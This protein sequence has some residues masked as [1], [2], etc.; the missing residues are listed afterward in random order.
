[1]SSINTNATVTLTVNGKQAQDMLDNLTKKSKDLEHAIENAAKAGNKVELKRLQKELKQTNRQIAQIESATAGVEKVLKNL[2]KATPKELNKTLATLKK[3]LNGIERGTE[4]WH[5]QAEAIKRVKAELAKVN[6]E[7]T[8]GEGFWDRFNRK[9]NDWQTTLMGMIAAATGIIMAGRSAVKAYADIDAEMANVRKFTGMAKEQVEDLNEEFKKMDTRSSREQLNILAEEAGKLG[10]QSKEDIMGFVKA[11]DQINVALDELGD[12][13]TLT[14]SK[15]TNIFGDEERLGTEKALLS[16][17]SVIN[18]L[19]QNCT[20]SAPYLANFAKRMAG[21]GAQ[22]EMTIPQIMGLAAVL[23]SQGQAVEMSATAVSKLIMDMFKQQD[24]IIKATGM[25]A[26]KFKQTLAKGTN[27]G[28]LMLLDTLDK[29]GNIDV[30]APIFKDMGENGARVAQVISALAGNLDMI[31]WEQS[32]AAKAF[33]EATSVNKE[34]NVQNNTVQAGLDKARKRVKE[35]AIELGEKLQPVM[36]HVLSSTTLMLKV[37]STLVDFILKYKGT[38]ITLTA[39]VVGYYTA[40]KLQHLWSL[41]YIAV[42][43]LK[44]AAIAIENTALAAS[45]LKHKVLRGEITAAAAAQTFFNKVLKMTPLGVAITA[46]T[47]LIGLYVKFAK[48]SSTA[49][50]AQKRLKDINEEADRNTRE[51]INRIEQLKRTIE[52]ESLSVNKRQK[53]IEELQQII[54]DYHASISEEGQLYGHNIKILKNYTEQLKNSAKI[55]A[56]LDKLPDAEKQRDVHFNE[57]PHN[58]QDAYFN[59]KQGQSESEAIRSANVSPAAYRAWK[60]QQSRLD[61][62]V[63]QYNN[64]IESLTADNQRLA[65]EAEKLAKAEDP[66]KT[67]TPPPTDNS[68]KQERFKE[69]KD[70]K[71]KE[72]ALN[73]ISYATGQQNYEQYQKRILEIEIEYQTKIL[74]HSDLTEIEKLEAQAAYAEAEKKQSEQHTK[75]TVEQET[76]LYNEAMSI[77]KQR[78][79]DG[80]IDQEIYQQSMELLE[81]NHLKRMT[82]IYEE[83][84][85]E[86]TQAQTRYQDKLIA[87]Q[88]RRQQETEAAQKKHQD[89]LKKIKEEFF[90]DNRSERTS[91]YMTDLEALKVVYDLEIKAAD[92]NAKEK[93]RIEEDYQKAKKALRKKYGIDELDDNRSFLEEWTSATQ[94]WLQSDM[95]KAVTGSL[96]VISSGMSSIFQQ[97]SSLIQAEADIQISAIEKRYQ[98]EISNAEGNNYIV[99]KLEKQ[100]EQEVAKV[101]SDANKKM[102]KMQ[103]MQAIAQTATSAINAYSSAA[104]VPLIGYILAPIAAASAVAAGMLQVAAI[105]KQQE[106]SAAQ[107]YAKGGFTGEGGKYEVAGIVHKGEWVASQELLQ[108]PVARPMIEALDYAQRTNT[109]GSLR[110]DDVSRSIV[111]PSVYA[112]SAPSSPT[113]IL[114]PAQQQSEQSDKLMKEYADIMRQLKD[115]LSEPFVTVNTVTGDTGI[116]KAQDEY[117]QL[118]RNKSPKSRRK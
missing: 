56:A 16:V 85:T 118:I 65:D 10:K 4:Q 41:R 60:L 2:D 20:A 25:N 99:K 77:Q 94:E 50:A 32:E 98:T 46:M 42:A 39:A 116:K 104:A 89:Q 92:N 90:G 17:G 61:K 74:Q 95:G 82:S 69:E 52:N 53:A 78:Y 47:L 67:P 96:D 113:V 40:V 62:T 101:K 108:S 22:A 23:D 76:Q 1:M 103:V 35:M 97:M 45:I 57:A 71:A 58:I 38:L 102:F 18:E 36:R 91:K 11:A 37:L 73:R 7:L 48:S 86:Y 88:K 68:K 31:R 21:V 15:L 64:I 81:L 112:Q 3:Q 26:E 106:A 63:T 24:K 87:D 12:G 28:L 115:R 33:K 13:A 111:A 6:T 49:A 93:L 79:I 80:K 83:G 72:E 34:Y 75:I 8:V 66:K 100:K 84:T 105:K 30:L 114:Q 54:P 59:E 110:S 29:L 9:M 14:L 5:R 107:G 51:E 19:S 117:D 70:W 55:K 44:A 27:E 43:K 109:I